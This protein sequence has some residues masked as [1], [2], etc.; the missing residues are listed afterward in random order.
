MDPQLRPPHSS[1]DS[2]LAHF[3]SRAQSIHPQI[4]DADVYWRVPLFVDAEQAAA[5]V[6][7]QEEIL[8]AGDRH[9]AQHIGDA[10]VPTGV[11]L[12]PCTP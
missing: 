6:V 10:P 9:L 12:R 4:A 11:G 1:Q 5:Q 7:H 8:E 2:I 3:L